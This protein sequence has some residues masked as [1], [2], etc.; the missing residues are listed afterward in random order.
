MEEI[1]NSFDE[2]DEFRCSL[3][4]SD[5]RNEQARY[6]CLYLVNSKKNYDNKAKE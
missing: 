6:S 5:G 3:E 1:H 4:I 2:R